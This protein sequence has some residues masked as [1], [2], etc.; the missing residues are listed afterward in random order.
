MGRGRKGITNQSTKKLVPRRHNNIAMVVGLPNKRDEPK[1]SLPEEALEF[2]KKMD[3]QQ[4]FDVLTSNE[5]WYVKT[6]GINASGN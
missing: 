2:M 3:K 4:L 1:I 6:S 5:D